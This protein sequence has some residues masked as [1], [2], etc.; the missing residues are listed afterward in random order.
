M[1]MQNPLLVTRPE[2]SSGREIS[3]HQ[4]QQAQLLIVEKGTSRIQGEQGWWLAMPDTAIYI[5]PNIEHRALYNKETI[6]LNL[7]FNI[8]PEQALPDQISLIL[9]SNLMKALAEQAL[10]L[11]QKN[12][13]QMDLEQLALIKQLMLLQLGQRV[14]SSTLYVASGI[15]KRLKYITNTL[16]NDPSCDASLQQFAT[17]V[18]SSVRTI[19]RLFAQETGLS[20]SQWREKMRMIIAIERLIA[21][22]SITELAIDL[23]YQSSSSF[24]T[25]FRRVMGIPPK[26]Y[27]QQSKSELRP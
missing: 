22:Q 3:F 25:A 10:L 14:Q 20:F 5:P 17:E 23:G 13:R 16:K 2:H 7:V 27:L 1:F 19:A 4:H 26:Q 8:Y 18:H 24:S 9:V 6:L 11:N 15:D 21:G 12:E